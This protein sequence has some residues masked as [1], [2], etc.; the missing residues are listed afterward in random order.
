MGLA[1][2]DRG[3]LVSCSLDLRQ[4]RLRRQRPVLPV[5]AHRL[6]GR[7]WRHG[8][9]LD[10]GRGLRQSGSD[11]V[12]DL[13]A[14]E[15]AL[16]ESLAGNRFPPFVA[17]FRSFS[18]PGGLSLDES[19]DD[20]RRRRIEFIK[21]QWPFPYQR[22]VASHEVAV[23]IWSLGCHGRAPSCWPGA[24]LRSEGGTRTGRRGA[25]TAAEPTAAISGAIS[26]PLRTAH[27]EVVWPTRS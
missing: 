12:V 18:V 21:D 7:R 19:A 24:P 10:R 1:P 11:L 14:P 5:D 2:G 8:L 15:A 16:L 26:V 27:G 9:G 20:A 23:T 6:G 3:L 22:P 17:Y 25:M 13:R 4:P